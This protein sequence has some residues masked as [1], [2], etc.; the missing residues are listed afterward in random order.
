M[1]SDLR[2]HIRLDDSLANLGVRAATIEI[3]GRP[4]MTLRYETEDGSLDPAAGGD[5]FL[6]GS[7]LMLMAA[8]YPVQ[9]HGSITHRCLWNV[10]ELQRIW[11]RWK[12]SKY[13]AIEITAANLCNGFPSAEQGAIAAFSGGVDACYTVQQNAFDGAIMGS[14]IEAALFIHGLDIPEDEFEKFAKAKLRGDEILSTTGI[15]SKSVRTNLRSLDQDWQ[16]CFGLAVASCLALFQTEYSF[17]LIGSSYEYESLRLPWGSSP[18]TD[19][20]YSTG[21]MEIRHD[22]SG[23]SRTQKVASIAAWPE[24]SRGVR[25]CWEG[26]NQDRNCGKCEK[27]VRTYLNFRAAGIESPECFEKIPNSRDIRWVRA[28]TETRLDGIKESL[29]FATKTGQTGKWL[30]DLRFSVRIN[31]L[32]VLV[33]KRPMIRLLTTPIRVAAKWAAGIRT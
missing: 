20:L 29:D 26:K 14:R 12:P 15:K 23:A 21:F 2:S 9:I 16:D 5:P 7:L 24:A 28:G 18:V 30:E 32:K 27:C 31:S 10:A 4:A 1:S 17:G 19:N 33:N 13:N 11:S 22:G 25:V 6:L 3:P 8:G